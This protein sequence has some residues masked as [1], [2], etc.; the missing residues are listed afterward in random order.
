M[1]PA[2]K[3]V[4]TLK[5]DAEEKPKLR[6]AF[7]AEFQQI[8]MNKHLVMKYRWS[9]TQISLTAIQNG[10]WLAFMQM[11]GFREH[12]LRIEKSLIA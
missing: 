9:I 4:G 6:V 8:V 3:R 12:P 10:N 1:I 2:T 11:M 5:V 7:I